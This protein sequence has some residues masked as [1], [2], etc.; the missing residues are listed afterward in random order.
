MNR[1]VFKK[2][3]RETMCLCINKPTQMSNTLCFQWDM[4]VWGWL[5]LIGRFKFIRITRIILPL[6]YQKGKTEQRPWQR[7]FWKFLEKK[8]NKK[9]INRKRLEPKSNNLE[10]K[11]K[12]T[13]EEK[14]TKSKLFR[15]TIYLVGGG[16]E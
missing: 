6:T 15:R 1:K 14:Q 16:G 11:K 7:K 4:C 3:K 9:K 10:K 12:I 8:N 13:K 2:K 5:S